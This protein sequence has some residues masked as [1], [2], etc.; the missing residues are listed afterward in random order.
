MSL[1]ILERSSRK[2]LTFAQKFELIESSSKPGFKRDEACKEYGI[3]RSCISTILK[4]KDRILAMAN[5]PGV[6]PSTKSFNFGKNSLLE[7]ILYDWYKNQAN[8][9]VNVTGPMLRSKAEELS[10]ASEIKCNFSCGWL[11]GFKRRYK[12][13]FKYSRKEALIE[14][15]NNSLLEQILAQW[16]MHQQSCNIIVSGPALKAKAEELAK[17]CAST[18]EGF[19]FTTTWLDSFKK[20]FGIRFRTISEQAST[21]GT[22]QT[23]TEPGFEPRSS[24]LPL[25]PPPSHLWQD[26]V[27]Q[28]PPPNLPHYPNK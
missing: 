7:Q 19:K 10:S 20:R 1:K 11:E 2:R 8:V 3:K 6:D 12:I 24:S 17:V 21:I 4:N 5:S 9:G 14:T 15:K 18:S 25:P 16:V 28:K 22:S 13:Q 23:K 27:D 26:L